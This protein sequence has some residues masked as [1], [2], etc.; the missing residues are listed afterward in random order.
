MMII[1][2]IFLINLLFSFLIYKMSENSPSEFPRAE[3]MPSNVSFDSPEPEEHKETSK[4][5]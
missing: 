4:H 2:M 1:M 5:S 3:L